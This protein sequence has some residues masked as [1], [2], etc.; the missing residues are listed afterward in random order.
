MSE[1]S[2]TLAE[3]LSAE[4][5]Q[6][7][8]VH[9]EAVEKSRAAQMQSAVEAAFIKVL[10]DEGGSPLLIKRIPFICTDVSKIKGDITWIKWV[11]TVAASTIVLVGLPLLG[12]LLLQTI[13]NSESIV[14]LQSTVSSLSK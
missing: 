11:I 3:S 7:A 2:K 9:A 6:A 14:G 13:Q 1:D 10:S 4:T 12:W 8:A 5:A